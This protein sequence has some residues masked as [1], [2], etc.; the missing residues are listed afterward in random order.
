MMSLPMVVFIRPVESTEE[1]VC[2]NP[3][4]ETLRL[5]ANHLDLLGAIGEQETSVAA[6]PGTNFVHED[7]SF[8]FIHESETGRGEQEYW[9]VFDC[10]ARYIFQCVLKQRLQILSHLLWC[11]GQSRDSR[12]DFLDP[13]LL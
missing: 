8:S 10:M 4:I 9:C 7:V 2:R 11:I 1:I 12:L 6:G 13:F 3:P 5:A